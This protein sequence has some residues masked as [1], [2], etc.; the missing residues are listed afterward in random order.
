MK[1]VLKMRKVIDC[2]LTIIQSLLILLMVGTWG[3]ALDFN[4][5][6]VSTM[7][8]INILCVIAL[9]GMTWIIRLINKG[10]VSNESNGYCEK[11]R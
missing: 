3:G 6:P 2:A 11:S 7:L 4:Y 8:L 5:M 10:E 9:V 1:E